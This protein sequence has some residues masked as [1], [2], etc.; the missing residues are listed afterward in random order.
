LEKLTD[1]CDGLRGHI[2]Q[3]SQE[4]AELDR[5]LTQISQQIHK[6]IEVRDASFAA[7]FNNY[8][9]KLRKELDELD[10]VWSTLRAQ[11]RACKPADWTAELILPAKGLNSHAK[12]LSR[13]CDE[14]ITAY[15]IFAR[16]YKGFTAV[17]L[18]VWLLTACQND[19]FNLTG[20]ILFLAREIARH[21]EQKRGN[22]AAG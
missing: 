5:R 13:A 2:I 15:D 6:N 11:S 18:N 1:Y 10:T 14:F 8:C 9:C 22:H 19:F 17:K 16:T 12:T 3:A 7:D 20:K 4:L 21:T